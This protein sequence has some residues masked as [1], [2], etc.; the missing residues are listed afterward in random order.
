M[1]VRTDVL[2]RAMRKA[3]VEK[4]IA[5]IKAQKNSD[6]LRFVGI[7][8]PLDG[9]VEGGRMTWPYRI[10]PGEQTNAAYR[11]V[12]LLPPGGEDEYVEGLKL[13]ADAG[14][15]AQTHAVG[16]ETI[17]VIVRAYERVNSEKPIKPL[18]WAIMH[19]FHPVRRGAEEDGRDR[20]HGDD[21][22]PS[23]AARAQPAPLV[24]RR[25]RGLCDPDPQGD[26]CR[27]AGRRR[28]RRAGGAGRSVSLD[29]VDDD[30]PG[31]QGLRARQGARDHRRRRR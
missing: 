11:G 12:L 18:N 6:M 10:V 8:F 16:D 9:G 26:R 14:L 31:A 17:D 1:T 19:L 30:A 13:I 24:G 29:V 22:G 15:Q 5:A 2:Y 21:A 25:A 4:G 23:G 7:K 3:E 20:H 27:R 28:H